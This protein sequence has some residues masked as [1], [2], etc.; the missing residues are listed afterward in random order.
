VPH[1]PVRAQTA[2]AD[3][4]VRR[5]AQAAQL[6]AVPRVGAVHRE[7]VVRAVPAGIRN[8][9]EITCGSERG[10]EASPS[11]PNPFYEETLTSL[12]PVYFL[13]RVCDTA[14]ELGKP[15]WRVHV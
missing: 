14:H 9:D 1:D 8:A 12:A 2:Q 11:C 15:N 6:L 10:Q 13:D 3:P 5:G 7:A 4:R